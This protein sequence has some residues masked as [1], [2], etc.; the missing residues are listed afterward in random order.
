MN[1]SPVMTQMLEVGDLYIVNTRARLDQLGLSYTCERGFR[2]TTITIEASS[3]SEKASL[4]KFMVE[5]NQKLQKLKELDER[6]K[7][8]TIEWENRQKLA[9]VNRWRRLTLRKP[10]T[11]LR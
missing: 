10:L 7:Q 8:D 4:K 3:E 6:F 11:S 2:D 9:K 1:H 5:V